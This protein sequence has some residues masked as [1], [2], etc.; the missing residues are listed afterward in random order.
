MKGHGDVKER[1]EDMRDELCTSEESGGRVGAGQ[2][3]VPHGWKK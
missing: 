1:T 2:A 3:N